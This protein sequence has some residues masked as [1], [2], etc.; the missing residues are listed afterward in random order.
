MSP[1]LHQYE[2][3]IPIHHQFHL[4]FLFSDSSQSNR[5]ENQSHFKW[6]HVYF[7][8]IIYS[9]PP[10]CV[11]VRVF[12]CCFKKKIC[13]LQFPHHFILCVLF[14]SSKLFLCQHFS[15]WVSSVC[16]AW[17]KRKRLNISKNQ[18]H[19]NKLS[20]CLLLS[21]S[22]FVN[23][24]FF[25]SLVVAHIISSSHFVEGFHLSHFCQKISIEYTYLNIWW[26]TRHCSR[27]DISNNYIFELNVMH[28]SEKE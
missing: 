6:A 3:V 28:M 24:R 4:I 18:L 17:T 7:L 20:K 27:I 19:V 15:F 13:L 1:F 5:N 16:L 26:K 9:F 22:H 25:F 12:V 21:C 11:C 8:F 23:F 10:E 2:R 14:P